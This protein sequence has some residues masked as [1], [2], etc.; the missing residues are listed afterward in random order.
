MTGAL[1]LQWGL[2]RWT[3]DE[4]TRRD[5]MRWGVVRRVALSDAPGADVL[6]VSALFQHGVERGHGRLVAGVDY[7]GAWGCGWLHHFTPTTGWRPGRF[8]YEVNCT[9]FTGESMT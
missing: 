7:A 8:G 4:G 1:F 3:G 5:D 2:T 9:G 6:G